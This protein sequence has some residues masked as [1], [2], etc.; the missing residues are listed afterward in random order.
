MKPDF[1]VRDPQGNR[2]LLDTKWKLLDAAQNG[3]RQKY[4]LSQSDFYQLYAYGQHCLQ[5][6]GDVVLI[7]PL[8]NAFDSPLPVF[9]FPRSPD[10]RLWVLPFRLDKP[11][12]LLPD[13]QC[14][15]A[16][17]KGGPELSQ[18]DDN[19]RTMAAKTTAPMATWASS[20]E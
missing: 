7:Y 6:G 19:S 20:L 1:L 10:L 5:G 2:L 9:D 12:L 11:R 14:L 17:F 15:R 18:R 8:T 4:Q 3:G 16:I 13:E